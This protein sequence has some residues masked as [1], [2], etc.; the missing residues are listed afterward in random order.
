M[1]KY[2]FDKYGLNWPTFYCDCKIIPPKGYSAITLFGNVYTRKR[3]EDVVQTLKTDKGLKWINHENIHCNDKKNTKNSWIVFYA[4]YIW[5]FIKMWPFSTLSWRR[6]YCTIPFELNAYYNEHK[7]GYDGSYKNYI[8]SNKWRKEFDISI[9]SHR[10][11]KDVDL[12]Y[13]RKTWVVISRMDTDFSRI[14]NI[15]TTEIV[16]REEYNDLFSD[17]EILFE[18][19][20]YNEA[21]QY[22]TDTYEIKVNS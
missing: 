13:I 15:P 20:N 1:R 12:T 21:N 14:T 4:L 3:K 6:A 11:Q 19:D 9:M 22:I 5:Y 16:H 2:K 10:S 18:S 7:I 8:Y 17:C